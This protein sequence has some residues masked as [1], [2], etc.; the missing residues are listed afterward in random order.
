MSVSRFLSLLFVLALAPLALYGHDGTGSGASRWATY[1]GD[2]HHLYALS[3]QPKEQLSYPR[4]SGYE[5]VVLFDTSA[6]QT[7]WVRTE[8][9]EVLAEFS[10]ALP[11]GTKVGLIACDV[12]AVAM[13]QGM[14]APTAA[15]WDSAIE[16][17]KKRTPLGTT[18]M[19]RALGTAAKL[20]SSQADS[21][22]RTIV[23]IG[24]GI[25]R[26]GYLTAQQHRE[27]VESLISKRITV[28]SLLI[29]PVVDLPTMAS[30]AN[31]TGGVLFSRD[32]I[33]ESTQ[34]IGRNLGMSAVTPVGW[35][36]KAELPG[37]N[38]S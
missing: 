21:I 29:G 13:S 27:M 32:A 34:M 6:S 22:Q 17:L 10:T 36:E 25:N 5:V 24:D 11:V 28:S 12:E 23:Y 31:Q 37:A 30:F 19:G 2:S 18:D 8:G 15:D 26:Q 38:R 9:L 33:E 3:L 1:E 14:I 35:V 7:G 4:P 16:K 20:F